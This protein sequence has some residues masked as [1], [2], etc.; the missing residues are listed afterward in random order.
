[1]SPTNTTRGCEDPDVAYQR[2]AER[3]AAMF[4]SE[5]DDDWAYSDEPIACSWC[6]GFVAAK[7]A[8]LGDDGY[9]VCSRCRTDLL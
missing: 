4:A 9:W 6:G 7:A 2:G 3:V 8:V 1:M 5:L